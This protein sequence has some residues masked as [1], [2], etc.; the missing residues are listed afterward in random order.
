MSHFKFYSALFADTLENYV[1]ESNEYFTIQQ[2][3]LFN[4]V[5]KH[6][7]KMDDAELEYIK[8][9]I[10]LSSSDQIRNDDVSTYA[11]II[12]DISA[13]IVLV[14]LPHYSKDSKKYLP[15]ALKLQD[16]RAESFKTKLIEQLRSNNLLV[17]ILYEYNI[18]ISGSEVHKNIEINAYNDSV[19]RITIDENKAENHILKELPVKVICTPTAQGELNNA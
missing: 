11:E 8:Q 7:Y 1:C 14:D 15:T 4:E 19:T 6:I 18:L 3:G 12:T 9:S 13:N 16:R 5:F 10:R 2:I 17:K